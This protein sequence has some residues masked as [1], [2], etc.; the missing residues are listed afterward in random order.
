MNPKVTVLMSV[1]NGEK[2]L[3][4]A[5]DSIL[6]QTFT[7]YEF[8]IVDDG[9]TDGTVD[10]INS[11]DDQR[12]LLIR[13]DRNVGLT[14]SLNRGLGLARGEY[15]ARMDADDISLPH[16]FSKQVAFMDAHSEVGACGAYAILI[17]SV[18]TV[19]GRLPVFAGRQLEKYYWRPSPLA[20]PTAMIRFAR[21]NQLR[22]DSQFRYA[23]DYDLW[24]TIKA[25]SKLYNLP[26]DLLLY[27]VHETAISRDTA[28]LQAQM[29]YEIFCKHIGKHKISHREYKS[30]LDGLEGGF[31]L[32]PVRRALATKKL[33]RAI[34]QPYLFFF[35]D[36]LRYAHY[37]LRLK[38]QTYNVIYSTVTG[39]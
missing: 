3:R 24:L 4:E 21:S 35:V 23:Q 19:I 31:E 36:D 17:D 30:L 26:E 10:I 8:I 2:Y 39:R 16:R 13:N 34:R 9:S 27:R 22:Y 20:H 11:Y 1:Y 32:G 38:S 33:A 15:V 7:D 14:V 29:A 5:I 25:K 6:G 28:D 37:W 18:G 12:V